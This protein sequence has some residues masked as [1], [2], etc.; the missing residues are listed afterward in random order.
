[1]Y[2]FYLGVADGC[3]TIIVATILA[4]VIEIPALQFG[5]AFLVTPSMLKGK[6]SDFQGDDYEAHD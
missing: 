4:V 2:A 6:E 3:I 1:M 5:K